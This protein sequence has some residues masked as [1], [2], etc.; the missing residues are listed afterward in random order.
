MRVLY[1]DTEG[2]VQDSESKDKLN[3]QRNKQ[4]QQIPWNETEQKM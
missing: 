4:L 3:D 2:E 1:S